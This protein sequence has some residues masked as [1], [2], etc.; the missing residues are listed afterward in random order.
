MPGGMRVVG[1]W[2]VPGAAMWLAFLNTQ[3]VGASER[4]GDYVLYVLNALRGDAWAAKLEGQL[5]VL[6]VRPGS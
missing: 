3:L 4:K 1:G 5:E 2:I 6:W